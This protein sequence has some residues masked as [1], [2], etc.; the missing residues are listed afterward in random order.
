MCPTTS[1]VWK[2]Q[3]SFA[4]VGRRSQN[5]DSTSPQL[6]V[7]VTNLSAGV[8]IAVCYDTGKGLAV[9]IPCHRPLW[10]LSWRGRGRQAN[11]GGRYDGH[12]TEAATQP[13]RR[14]VPVDDVDP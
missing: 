3:K 7:A 5:R 2:H 13:T 11:N 6:P 8:R 9:D 10:D 4:G 1:P 14:R 12:Q